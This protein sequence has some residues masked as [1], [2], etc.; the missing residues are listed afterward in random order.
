MDTR[1]LAD[2]EGLLA[3]LRIAGAVVLVTIVLLDRGARPT[4]VLVIEIGALT[5]LAA[6]GIAAVAF[7]R[8]EGHETDP[9]AVTAF[10]GWTHVLD[11]VVLLGLVPLHGFETALPGAAPALLVPV[12]AGIRHGTRG[13]G[14]A[15]GLLLAAFAARGL[16][17]LEVWHVAVGLT[18]ALAG[19]TMAGI[20]GAIAGR[21]ADG[22]NR[23]L[24]DAERRA[25]AVATDAAEARDAASR[26]AAARTELELLHDVLTAGVGGSTVAVVERTSRI[27]RDAFDAD[28]RLVLDPDGPSRTVPPEDGLRQVPVTVGDEHLAVLMLPDTQQVLGPDSLERLSAQI[29]LVLRAAIALDAKVQVAARYRELDR[30][31]TDFVAITSHELRTP[32]TAIRGATETIRTHGA[33]LSPDQRR[34]LLDAVGR[35]TER[36]VRL[37]DDLVTISHADAGTLDVRPIDLPLRTVVGDAVRATGRER[38]VRLLSTPHL[39]V[40]ADP[41]RLQQ[42]LSNVL[43]NAFE[44]GA[45]PVQ[46]SWRQLGDRAQIRVRD[47]GDGIPA[48]ARERVFLRFSQGVDPRH[49]TRGSGLGLAVARDLVRAMGGE[50]VVDPDV[51][52]G[53]AFV[54]T[55]RLAPRPVPAELART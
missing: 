19:V 22:A 35:Q 38:D 14:R 2:V 27:L 47:H 20:A 4:S 7:L 51:V 31:K 33:L 29:G 46:V 40:H 45:P 24:V 34:E 9:V 41:V 23:R 17:S 1:S 8:R 32:I 21:V 26:A 36:L 15:T 6:A 12:L 37:V 3:R 10:T 43:E 53:A 25:D 52:D 18:P 55:V 42:V 54:I 49:H 5:A 48:D 28:V 13:A 50:L 39:Q 16:L 44:H 11:V 30:L